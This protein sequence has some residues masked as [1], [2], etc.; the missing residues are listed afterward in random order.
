MSSLFFSNSYFP[1]FFPATYLKCIS[2]CSRDVQGVA[3]VASSLGW[4]VDFATEWKLSLWAALMKLEV[5]LQLLIRHK[6]VVFEENKSNFWFLEARSI[7]KREILFWNL[8][9]VAIKKMKKKYY[10]WE[11]CISLREVKVKTLS[12]GTA[13][14]HLSP[15][16]K[17]IFLVGSHWGKWTIQL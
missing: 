10:S 11:E 9:Q 7:L 3:S 14:P 12:C 4:Y 17:V 6:F 16:L 13:Y 15:E 2:Q 8:I 5:W 1:F